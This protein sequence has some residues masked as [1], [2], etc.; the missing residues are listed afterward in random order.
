MVKNR[1]IKKIWKDEYK[2]HSYEVDVKGNATL[3][4]LCQFMQESAWKHA[5]NM[6]V[7]FAHLLNKNLIWVLSRQLIKMQSFPKLGETIQIHTCPK[8]KDRLFYYRDFRILDEKENAIGGAATVW[9]AIDV[10][11]RKPQK[12]DSYFQFP[13]HKDRV[14]SDKLNRLKGSLQSIDGTTSIRV[15]YKDLDLHEHVNNVRYIEWMLDSFTL[16]FQKTHRLREVEINY[17]AEAL[18]NDILVVN[19]EKKEDLNYFHNVAR[20][21]DKKELCKARTL[22]QLSDHK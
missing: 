4:I 15:N 2:I 9:F 10:T 11:T 16:E 7:G 12:P 19:Y 18:Y 6:R 20:N 8:G 5:E 13:L 21:Q 17:L 22:W 1:E 14:F 3:P